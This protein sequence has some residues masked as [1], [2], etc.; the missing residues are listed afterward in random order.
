MDERQ[1]PLEAQTEILTILSKDE[2]IK[3]IIIES[4]PEF[5][6]EDF[7]K[8][9]VEIVKNKRLEV[10]IGLESVTD[11]IREKCINKGFS[12]K[13][14]EGALNILKKYDIRVLTYVLLK[15]P[16]L[17]EWEAIIEAEKTIRYAFQAGTDTVILEVLY[18]EA[19]SIVEYLYKQNMYKLP[20]LWS[21][22]EI[23]KKTNNLGEIRIGYPQDSP[24]PIQIA[25]NCDKCTERFYSAF[26]MFNKSANIAELKSLN[27]DCKK[28]WKKEI[29]KER[30]RD[31]NLEVDIRKKFHNFLL[32]FQ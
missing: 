7:V 24:P 16:F 4:R 27:C 8:E 2:N 19:D 29:E 26:H 9:L 20:W 22:V 15:P 10:G 32:N 12:L 6:R 14:Y 5:I 11:F 21:V 31:C 30:K 28:E 18:L 17:N 3:K 25:K 23:I 13:D 1:I